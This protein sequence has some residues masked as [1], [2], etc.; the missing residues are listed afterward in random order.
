MLEKKFL[1]KLNSLNIKG[2]VAIAVSGGS[3]SMALALLAS[4]LKLDIIAITVDHG[5]RPESNS[6]AKTVG[7]WLK[8]HDIQ[9]VILQWDG[10]KPTSNIQSE[11]R[12]ARYELMSDFCYKNKIK[13]LLVAH[14]MD[15][16]AE[17]VLL[18]LM[19]GSGVD[20]LSGIAEIS[21]HNKIKIIRPLLGFSKEELRQYLKT[22]KQEWVNDP[23]NEND[24]FD[25]IKIRK[26][27]NQS[28]NPDILTAR[29]V[30]TAE[31]MARSRDF[32]EEE[33]KKHM[34]EISSFESEGYAI[35]NL[36][37]LL[38]S[39][40]EIIFRTLSILLTKI[41]GSYYKPRFENIKNLYEMLQK[42]TFKA[43][44]LWGCRIY[45]PDDK[46]NNGNIFIVRELSAISG[47]IEAQKE[48]VWDGRFI[49]KYSGKGF[50]IGA[51]GK[52]GLSQITKNN[53]KIDKL[54]LPKEIIYSLPSLKSKD[55]KIIAV[56]HINYFEK[57]GFVVEL[58]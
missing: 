21:Q 4:N 15:D 16:Q 47:D 36:K 45:K 29:L 24:K 30:N 56:P 27:I 5:L 28:E 43:A 1:S 44:T 18:R 37:K 48:C 39:H 14:T 50:Y 25:R 33:L 10:T 57:E 7:N 22:K 19:R 51:L 41:S 26:F 12:N 35:V 40:E 32:I 6:E 42:P 13:T 3:D 23:S 34:A 31:N 52:N 54:N 55:G 17:T 49:C 38:K 8:K 20:G 46:K 9:H 58:K 2:K 11:A 53:N